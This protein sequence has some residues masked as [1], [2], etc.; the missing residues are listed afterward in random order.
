MSQGR[1]KWRNKPEPP[2]GE[3]VTVRPSVSV[4]TLQQ[5]PYYIGISESTAGARGISMNLVVI[6]PAARSEP[7]LHQGFET[8][9]Y[10]LRGRVQTFY[11]D[12][13]S[14]S[15]INEPGDF[16]YIPEGV[17]HLAVNLS[18]SEEAVGLVARNSAGEQETVQL[19]RP[20]TPHSD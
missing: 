15:V 3:L 5:L 16:L 8:A 1:R 6:P 9:I 2:H 19:Y 12:D 13:L 7:H 11:G 4:E 18:D 17:P 14:R 20:P 10:L